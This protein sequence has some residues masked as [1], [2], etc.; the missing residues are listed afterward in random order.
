MLKIMPFR[1]LVVLGMLISP[2]AQAQQ[3]IRLYEG[4]APGSENSTWEEAENST[5]LFNTRV[6]YN[7]TTPTLTAYLP[8]VDRATG[9]AVVVAPGGGFHTLSIDSEGIDVAKWLAA[10]GVA[11]F[12]LKYRVVRS[13]MNDPVAELMPKMAD[14]QKLDAENAPIVQVS[15]QSQTL[16]H[17]EN[18]NVWCSFSEA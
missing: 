3:V 18:N 17:S 4:K 15:D 5:N 14:K 13:L 7:V 1:F 2:I 11:A 10:K 9:T 6:I 16:T 8:S 12:V